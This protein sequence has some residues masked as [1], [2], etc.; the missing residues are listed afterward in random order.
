MAGHAILQKDGYQS[1]RKETSLAFHPFHKSK[2]VW[3]MDNQN[4]AVKR[5]TR[6]FLAV[7]V[8]AL[9]LLLLRTSTREVS[10]A[11]PGFDEPRLFGVGD[12]S[13]DVAA[14][15]MDGDGTLDLVVGNDG[16][17][18]VHLNDGDGYYPDGGSYN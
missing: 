9:C 12:M 17:N 10:A 8:A 18:W 14:G 15:D 2:E 4:R 7:F 16:V 13:F 5:P 3:K 6:V 11:D 1:A